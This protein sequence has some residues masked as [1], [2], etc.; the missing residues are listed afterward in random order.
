MKIPFVS[1]R[2]MERELDKEIREAFERV[3][4][5]SFVRSIM[6]YGLVPISIILFQY[7]FRN[8]IKILDFAKGIFRFQKK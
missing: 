7:I 5:G 4:A 8:A 1:F 6:R 3:Y 2:P